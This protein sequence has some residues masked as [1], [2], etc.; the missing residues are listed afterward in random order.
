MK[1]DGIQLM[2]GMVATHNTANWK[3]MEDNIDVKI[4]MRIRY[5][6]IN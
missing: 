4:N 6:V 5:T 3:K 2:H 1:I